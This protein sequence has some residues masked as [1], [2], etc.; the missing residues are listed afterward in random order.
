[1]TINTKYR[2]VNN[3]ELSTNIVVDGIS[4]I[5]NGTSNS[6]FDLKNKNLSYA[7][8]ENA[9]LKNVDLSGSTLTGA[10]LSGSVLTGCK[11]TNL[12]GTPA[13]LPDGYKKVSTCI[14]GP[15]V[16]VSGTDLSNQDLSNLD[17]T[18]AD[19]TNCNIH[20]TNFTG[21]IISDTKIFKNSE[22]LYSESSIN[23]SVEVL[24]NQLNKSPM[25]LDDGNFGIQDLLSLVNH[26]N[27]Q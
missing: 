13:S 16:N 19:L 25:N 12:Q 14:I 22:S 21:T 5:Q 1:M 6:L 9:Y 10:T 11:L 7:N 18:G 23:Q 3:E 17:L 27:N 24:E 2:T 20:N 8:L 26:I 15:N 4:L